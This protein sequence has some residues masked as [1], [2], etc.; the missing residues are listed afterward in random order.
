MN[1]LEL[2]KTS[3]TSLRNGRHAAEIFSTA[4]IFPG[5]EKCLD[6][7]TID[8]AIA[9]DV[10]GFNTGLPRGEERLDIA[11]VNSAILIEVRGTRALG[12]QNAR[13]LRAGGAFAGAIGV[14]KPSAKPFALPSA[15]TR[16]ATK[17][18]MK[19]DDLFICIA[20]FFECCGPTNTTQDRPSMPS[21]ALESRR[22]LESQSD[23]QEYLGILRRENRL[24]HC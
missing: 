10:A 16:I 9:V 12:R 24:N 11:A 22:Q 20:C 14:Q 1:A 5:D 18:G 3:A 15:I 7:L 2:P 19:N 8:P 17:S 13:Q 21:P 4:A 6:I 23:S